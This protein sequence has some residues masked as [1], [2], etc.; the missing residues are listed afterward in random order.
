MPI[1]RT[2]FFVSDGTGITA[3]MLGRTL[4]SQFPGAA[5]RRF[6]LPFV[7]TPDKAR[8]ARAQIDKSAAQ[9][10]ARAIVFSTLIEQAE[11]SIVAASDAL[12]LDLFDMFISPLEA[13][14]GVESSHMLGLSHGISNHGAYQERI[15]AINFTLAHD[16]GA[17]TA[18]LDQA[19][20][21]LIGVSRSGKT[22]TCLYLAMQ[23]GVRAANYPL[24]PEDFGDGGLPKPLRPFRAKLFGLA[25]SPERLSQIRQERRPDSHY[26]ALENC[27]YETRRVEGLYRSEGVK[28]ADT[29]TKSV[30]EIA[31]TIL[32]QTGLVRAGY[33]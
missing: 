10:G 7:D 13:E 27:R 6:T 26:A 1:C 23:Y 28:F 22:P 30:E 18:N 32:H 8:A 14:L 25:I 9:D 3:E 19:D 16:D 12:F 31:I 33:S 11:K 4:L 29:T 17:S 24:T 5:F 20:V 2:V 21:I 15:N